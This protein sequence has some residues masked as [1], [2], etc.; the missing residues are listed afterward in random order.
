MQVYRDI[1]QRSPEWYSAR[2]GIPTASEFSTVLA[3]GRDGGDSKTRKTYLLKLAGERLTGAPTELYDNAYMERGRVMEEEARD[4]YAF[5]KDVEPELV[6]FIRSGDA[7]CSPDAL[8][9]D[10]GLLEIKTAL[11]HILI[12]HILRGT[13]PAEH[14]AQCQGALWIAEREWIDIAIYW[15]GLPLFVKRATRD[16]A[17]IADLAK[18]VTAFNAELAEVVEQVRRYGQPSTLRADLA[19]SLAVA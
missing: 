1:V 11:P 3:K 6:G 13:F 2:A 10:N 8:V 12:G 14:V 4:A 17:Y 15:P 19:Q 5:M 16:E 18:A 7:G 9:G